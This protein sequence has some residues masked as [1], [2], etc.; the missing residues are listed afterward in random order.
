MSDSLYSRLDTVMRVMDISA[1]ELS[2]HCDV[3]SSLISRWRKGKRP[4]TEQS[5]AALSLSQA[6]I[7]LDTELR[8]QEFF[9]PFMDEQG[10]EATAL[11]T[12]LCSEEIPGLTPRAKPPALQSSGSYLA[13]QQI[14]LGE[15][16]FKKAAL[17]MLDSVMQLPPGQQV[18]V[19]AHNGFDLFLEN[20]PF[21]LQFLQKL[22][23]ATKRNTTFLLIN[24]RGFG[25][26][27][28]AHFAGFWLSAHLKGI[29]RSRYYEGEAPD[30]YF[31]GVIPGYW[32]GRVEHD[33]T[34]ENGLIATIFSDP[35]NIRKDEQHCAEQIARSKPASQYAF[36]NAPL[37][38]EDNVQSWTSGALPLWDEPDAL[39]PDGSFSLIC[40]VPSFGIMTK[41]EFDEIRGSS[42]APPI[43][44]YL[45]ADEAVF[46]QGAHRIILCKEDVHDALKHTRKKNEAL[47][48][49]LQR[50]TYVPRKI[51]VDELERL[52]QAMKEHDDFEVALMPYSAFKK[53]ELEMVCWH[54]SAA[55]GWLQ[56]GS[57]SVFANDPITS[58][59]FSAAIDHTWAK[60]HKGWK[61]KRD[62]AATL[63][64]WIAGEIESE[65][66]EDSATVK[67]WSPYE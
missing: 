51:L 42:E 49:L 24:R 13:R 2:R 18:I 16:G 46:A 59:S 26:E 4:L 48:I 32:S 63:R 19:C 27:N 41:A 61:R 60:L 22:S 54:N 11:M 31:V 10:D 7:E 64:K 65:P 40:R 28:N 56:D 14:L 3:S 53:L 52:L 47:S 30:E 62:V 66:E 34:A 25:M 23:R 37:G 50:K 44:D 15:R 58:G 20:V 12:Y 5:L 39:V 8:L 38:D 45:F 6:L 35:R 67:N 33:E 9:E 29:I 57:E 17:L 55:V 21:A 1:L 43:P 36:L